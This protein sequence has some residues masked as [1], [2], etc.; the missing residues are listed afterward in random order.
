VKKTVEQL[1]AVSN[2]DLINLPKVRI[3]LIS[4]RLYL[5]GNSSNLQLHVMAGG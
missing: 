5:P 2:K 1:F 4:P 3:T